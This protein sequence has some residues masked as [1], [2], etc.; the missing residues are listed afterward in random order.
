MT[1]R[2]VAVYPIY[3]LDILSKVSEQIASYNHDRKNTVLPH[4][5]TAV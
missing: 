4:Y 3:I 1:S 5:P 2:R